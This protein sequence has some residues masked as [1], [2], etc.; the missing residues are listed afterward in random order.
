MRGRLE[1]GGED[2]FEL[3]EVEGFGEVVVH[4]GGEAA[5]AVAVK[6]VGGEGD[7][8]GM[9]ARAADGGGSFEAVHAGHLAVHKDKVVGEGEGHG[10]G[11]EA[12]GGD[13]DLAA[14]LAE[15]MGG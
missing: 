2:P 15:E 5:F 4:A 12:V 13:I 8:G 3:S 14:N 11:F 1:P 7:D 6:S 10:D 9:G